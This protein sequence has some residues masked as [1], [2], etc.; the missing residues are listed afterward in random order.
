LIGEKAKTLDSLA[1]LNLFTTLV[2][3]V[4]GFSAIFNLA[5]VPDIRAYNRFTVFVSFF[6]LAAL[7]LVLE[8]FRLR[9]SRSKWKFFVPVFLLACFSLY[10][11]LLDRVGLLNTQDGD[12][13]NYL[14]EKTLLDRFTNIYPN[15]VSILQLPMTGFPI[16]SVHENMASYDHLRPFLF[17]KKNLRWSWPSFSQ[18]HRAWQDR[19]SSLEGD[20]LLKAA[21]YSGFGA[22]WVDRFGY[23]DNAV[24][25]T[26]GLQAAGAKEMLS[27][28]RHV[29]MDLR[30]AAEK[31]KFTE[32]QKRF[33]DQV[34]FWINS[35]NLSW[36]HG[37][38]GE[39]KNSQGIIFRWSND[40][41]SMVF[42]NFS[43]KKRNVT[44]EFDLASESNGKVLAY[45]NEARWE[46]NS[47]TLPTR[48]HL[49]FD[50]DGNSSTILSFHANFAKVNAPNDP[51][52]LF[53]YI[54][55]FAI[56]DAKVTE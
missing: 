27:N 23:K 31:L 1:V 37:F 29:I 45:T 35:V 13:A 14:S 8:S 38:Y 22:V 43:D 54:A 15:G 41:S 39:E 16:M 28:A 34:D 47:N 21:I 46:L 49:T 51:R 50:I 44:I 11:Q 12:M 19:L 4:G 18:R 10:D 53:F 9:F 33:D 55:D 3:T 32:T 5:V 26:A 40:Y 48:H 2:I 52:K 42:K 24:A 30:E 6:A 20:K 17:S 25:L 56:R 7:C 36:G